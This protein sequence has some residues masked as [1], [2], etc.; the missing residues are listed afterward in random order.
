[1][2]EAQRFHERII[3][4][5]HDHH[6]IQLPQ[7]IEFKDGPRLEEAQEIYAAHPKLT[8][9]IRDHVGFADASLRFSSNDVRFCPDMAFG[10]KP[11]RGDRGAADVIYLR[12][13]DSESVK[14]SIVDIEPSIGRVVNDWGLNL[15]GEAAWI[16]LHVPG[17]IARRVPWAR[18]ALFPIQKRC[19]AGIAR[20]N[21][22]T[23][24]RILGRGRV[25]LTDR[26]HAAV[27]GALMG[28]PVVALDNANGKVSAIFH[29]YLGTFPNVQFA[30]TAADA[31]R[32]LVRLLD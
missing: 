3:A 12:R 22:R 29:D 9:L 16:L 28:K 7:G 14:T 19:Y 10:N 23:A 5:N 24:T 4:E 26:L 25:V 13:T 18:R 6:V 17:A 20:L 27:L 32:I 8:I 1:W 31:N 11:I 21:L 2:D 30:R 15:F